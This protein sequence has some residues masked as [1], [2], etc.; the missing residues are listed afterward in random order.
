MILHAGIDGGLHDVL[1]NNV[2]MT[3]TYGAL[4]VNAAVYYVRRWW[5]WR[6][7]TK[8]SKRVRRQADL[9]QRGL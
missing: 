7:L 4:S 6:K 9:A 5:T 8:S 1:F 3:L 2:W